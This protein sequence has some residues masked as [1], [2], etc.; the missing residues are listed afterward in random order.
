MH[1][2][3]VTRSFRPA[4]G[5]VARFTDCT[6]HAYGATSDA[7]LDEF[8]RVAGILRLEL[9]LVARRESPSPAYRWERRVSSQLAEAG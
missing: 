9:Q 1:A 6:L 4:G 3:I 8:C 7:A 2:I 5:W